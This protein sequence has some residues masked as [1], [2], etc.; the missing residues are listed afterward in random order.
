MEKYVDECRM[1]RRKDLSYY[2]N[3]CKF[4]CQAAVITK[5][6]SHYNSSILDYDSDLPYDTELLMEHSLL[7]CANLYPCRV[8]CRQH[9]LNTYLGIPE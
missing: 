7:Y 4:C 3:Y 5:Q 6:N 2:N 8:F 9:L 1:E